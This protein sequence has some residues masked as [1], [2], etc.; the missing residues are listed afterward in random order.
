MNAINIMRH[1]SN[2]EMTIRWLCRTYFMDYLP[3]LERQLLQQG[4]TKLDT[5][6]V[7]CKPKE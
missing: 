1:F 4:K 7:N 6:Y 2:I 5:V 3:T